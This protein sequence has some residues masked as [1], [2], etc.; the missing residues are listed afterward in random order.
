VGFLLGS[1]IS[2]LILEFSIPLGMLGGLI[3]ASLSLPTR[4]VCGVFQHHWPD[5]SSTPTTGEMFLIAI[6]VSLAN[7]AIISSICGVVTAVSKL[8]K[9][10]S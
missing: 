1:I 2:A 6:V 4:A 5:F 9:G 8:N 10:R 7:G 3:W